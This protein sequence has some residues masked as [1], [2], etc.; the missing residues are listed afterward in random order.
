MRFA[1]RDLRRHFEDLVIPPRR[2]AFQCDP[3]FFELQQMLLCF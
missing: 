3:F 2:V 1:C